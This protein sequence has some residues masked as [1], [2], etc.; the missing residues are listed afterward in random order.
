MLILKHLYDWSFDERER[1]V[2]GSL[3]YQ[4]FCRIDGERVPDAKTL[5][6][7]AHFSTNPCS[8]TCWRIWSRWAG[9]GESS[10]GG[11]C[12]SIP[13]WWK[14]TS[15]TDGRHPDGR[16]RP[17]AYPGA[18]AAWPPRAAA[19]AQCR[20]PGVRDRA[21]QLYSGGKKGQE[22]GAGG[23]ERAVP[24]TRPFVLST[25]SGD[26]RERGAV[27]TPSPARPHARPCRQS[28]SP[29][30]SRLVPR[31]GRATI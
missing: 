9:R 24:S 8:R 27:A 22:G 18:V 25:L 10:R 30:S 6:R 19:C 1:E 26:R 2:R 7:V 3:V 21:A 23:R 15:I 20:A 11:A 16:R 14:R 28:G 31:P 12:V 5:I 13:P 4:A 29:S 17:R